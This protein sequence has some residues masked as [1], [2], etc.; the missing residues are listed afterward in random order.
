MKNAK[1]EE[2]SM[3][4]KDN[5]FILR[6]MIIS[7]AI[8][9]QTNLAGNKYLYVIGPEYFI[10]SFP[11][12]SFLHLTGVDTEL[13]AKSF[14]DL[15][16]K[17]KLASNQFTLTNHSFTNV[18]NK[19]TCLANIADLTKTPV[20]IIKDLTTKTASFTICIAD[21]IITLGLVKDK[22]DVYVPKSLRCYDTCKNYLAK[23]P[24]DF[25]FSM[26]AKKDN[27][28]RNL[29]YHAP[30]SKIAPNLEGLITRKLFKKLS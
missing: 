28:F 16:T 13:S 14:Y 9:Y 20:F 26:D 19:L 27:K 4:K 24:V 17:N 10:V 30:G 2:D 21:C 23:I 22:Y 6:P 7:S 15:A 29:L 8:N 25:I 5:R 11:N 1:A 3:K 12:S 18:R